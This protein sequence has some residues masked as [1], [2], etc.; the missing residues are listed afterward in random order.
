MNI[1][2]IT[3]MFLLSVFSVIPLCFASNEFQIN[4]TITA[5]NGNEITITDDKGKQLT[6]EGNLSKLNIG[7][8]V[9]F[10]AQIKKVET[11][12][13]QLTSEDIEFLSQC[14][15][16]Q[17]D[18]DI[19]PKLGNDGIGLILSSI[20]EKDCSKLNPFKAS[21]EYF[22]KLDV[23]K[24]VPLTPAGW[25]TNYLTSD[26]FKEYLSILDNAPW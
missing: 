26:E 10:E 7:D 8:R 18:I 21:R 4:G 9:I 24:V 6:L 12:P 14:A 1:G 19:I 25:N 23:N 11:F 17:N 22:R 16:D 20:K 13:T 15:I 3:V 5:I 2:R